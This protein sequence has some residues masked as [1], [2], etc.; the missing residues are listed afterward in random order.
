MARGSEQVRAWNRWAGMRLARNN[1]R[2]TGR[3]GLKPPG[4]SPQLLN[5]H[6]HR[7]RCT[8]GR[9]PAIHKKCKPA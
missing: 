8:R 4:P 9:P 7:V 1:R 3:K 2:A 6:R 5:R